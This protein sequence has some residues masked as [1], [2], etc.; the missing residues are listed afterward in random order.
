MT[1]QFNNRV[2]AVIVSLLAL[3]IIVGVFSII[4]QG[5]TTTQCPGQNGKQTLV[6]T[7]ASDKMC[8]GKAPDVLFGKAGDD[9]LWGGRGPDVLNGGTGYD[10]CR[11]HGRGDNDTFVSCEVQK[12]GKR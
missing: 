10:V 4:A 7:P 2:M 9:R 11:S 1:S 6:G 8:G 5:S 12:I 3:T